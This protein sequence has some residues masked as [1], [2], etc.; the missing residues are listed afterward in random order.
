MYYSLFN[1]RFELLDSLTKVLNKLYCISWHVSSLDTK[2]RESSHGLLANLA[3][4]IWYSVKEIVKFPI[5]LEGAT[6]AINFFL[7]TAALS[8]GGGMGSQVVRGLHLCHLWFK[9]AFLTLDR[10]LLKE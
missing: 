8:E 6:L 9:W 7:I 3:G 2:F 1:A 4:T 10:P 5:V